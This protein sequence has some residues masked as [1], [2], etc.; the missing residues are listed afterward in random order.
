MIKRAAL[1]FALLGLAS[2]GGTGAGM[3]QGVGSEAVTTTLYTFAGI[4]LIVWA[5]AAAFALTSY[6][7]EDRERNR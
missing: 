4:M 6:M 7:M 3:A 2:C 1:F 5:V